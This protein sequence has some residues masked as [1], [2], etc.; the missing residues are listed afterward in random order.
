M[1]NRSTYHTDKFKNLNEA[2]LVGHITLHIFLLQ[3]NCR[4]TRNRIVEIWFEHVTFLAFL[5]ASFECFASHEACDVPGQD[6]VASKY[7]KYA[8]RYKP[9]LSSE[10][11]KWY[12][13]IITTSEYT[14]LNVVNDNSVTCCSFTIITFQI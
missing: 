1:Q 2:F 7:V 14:K 10:N 5:A 11:S 9:R 3:N 4:I 8:S 13:E 12:G 6:F